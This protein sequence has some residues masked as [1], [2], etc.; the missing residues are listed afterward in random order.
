MS[1]DTCTKDLFVDEAQS[2]FTYYKNFKYL[3][4]AMTPRKTID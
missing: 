1:C 3:V 2:E 4:Q